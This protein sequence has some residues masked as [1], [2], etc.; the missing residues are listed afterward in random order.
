MVIEPESYMSW[1]DK[2]VPQTVGMKPLPARGKYELSR[3]H[4]A[5]R[6]MLGNKTIMRM[7][8]PAGQE[9]ETYYG[10]RKGVVCFSGEVEIPNQTEYGQAWMS[11]TPMEVLS[12][13]PGIKR[14]RGKVLVGGMGMG[15]F[16]RK[17]LERQQV[18]HVTV[19]DKDPG[20]L[21]Y[22]GNPLKDEFGDRLTLIHGDF[23]DQNA[24]SFDSVL[25]DI[26][27]G[28]YDISC[29]KQFLKIAASHPNAWGWGYKWID[30]VK[31]LRR[32]P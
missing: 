5:D 27:P 18:K 1:V 12:Q 19:V 17:M 3:S 6:V 16:A 32:N 26:W 15:W 29:D 24:N 8:L 13:R 10:N 14:G 11:L 21:E 7:V 30:K 28:I 9:L 20:V 22:F 31:E 23:Y 25:A 2:T 4:E